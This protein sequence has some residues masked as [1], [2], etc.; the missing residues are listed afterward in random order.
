MSPEE[1]SSIEHHVAETS[2][3][4]KRAVKTKAGEPRHKHASKWASQPWSKLGARSKRK[5]RRRGSLIGSAPPGMSW[6]TG[7]KVF[8]SPRS[9]PFSADIIDVAF[10]FSLQRLT[11]MTFC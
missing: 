6:A 8:A 7:D 10:Y 1:T 11:C 2:P 9:C 3:S 4:S 5:S